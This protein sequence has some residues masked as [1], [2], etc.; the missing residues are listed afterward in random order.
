MF[1]HTLNAVKSRISFTGWIPLMVLLSLVL[2]APDANAQGTVNSATD[3]L[4]GGVTVFMG[5]IM[6][7]L[8]FLMWI[9]FW[10]LNLV[11]DNN[12]IFDPNIMRM[13]YNIWLF[14]RDAVNVYF[15]FLLV[16]GAVL[17]T[18]YPIM[19]AEQMK[20][21]L[22]KFVAAVILVNFSWFIPR[23]IFDVSNV[24]TYSV[25]QMS[26]IGGETCKVP[27]TNGNPEPCKYI[28][29]IA[30]LS[31][32]DNIRTGQ[33]GPGGTWD[34]KAKP[35]VCIQTTTMNGTFTVQNHQSIIF[36]GLIVNYARL[37][38][39]DSLVD[40]RPRTQGSSVDISGLIKTLVKYAVV[41]VIHIALFFPLLAMVA[42]FFMR[43]PV[44][45]L[46]MAFM[47][48]VALGYV[49][50][51]KLGADMNPIEIIQK[52]F[53]AA[54]FLPLF[55]AL[56]LSLGFALLNAGMAIEA[57]TTGAAASQLPIFLGLRSFWQI[58]WL[59]MALSVLWS[60]VFAA[61]KKNELTAK[62]TETIES[63][64]KALG[65]YAVK[66]PLSVPFIPMGKNSDGTKKY[67]SLG[68]LAGQ[69]SPKRALDDVNRKLQAQAS[70]QTDAPKPAPD[71]YKKIDAT[72]VA[73]VEATPKFADALNGIKGADTKAAVE[74][75][76]NELKNSKELQGF[77]LTNE[78]ALEMYIERRRADGKLKSK[79]DSNLRDVLKG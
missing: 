23:V 70:G 72:V 56:P 43:I 44:L 31:Q 69:Y 79:E 59:F 76:M 15:A 21:Y 66:A 27:A 7:I 67:N 65:Q 60:G 9:L 35:L 34:C 62:I 39:L 51:D 2:F 32:T 14:T 53:L 61:L 12:F 74:A 19:F 33:T 17:W 63:S 40:E 1:T 11:T 75:A 71:T 5:M 77:K 46:T 73:K 16:I 22:P 54:A 52:K 37:R 26:R 57:P 55:V 24:M 8:N 47:P 48:F 10:M 30:F 13:V 45:W 6:N 25:Y 20:A 29:D 49:I 3:S 68:G 78:Q 58:F 42:A 38:M 64:G 28:N 4:L 18:V 41:L 50:G 36:N